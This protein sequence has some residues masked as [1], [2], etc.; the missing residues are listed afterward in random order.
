MESHISIKKYIPNIDYEENA[1]ILRNQGVGR[2]TPHL[3]SSIFE[4]CLLLQSHRLMRVCDSTVNFQGFLLEE[5]KDF[6][7]AEHTFLLLGG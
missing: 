2:L 4:F 7:K 6:A 5:L 1:K 3:W